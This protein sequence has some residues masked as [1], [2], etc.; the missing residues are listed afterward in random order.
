[1][2]GPVH[3]IPIAT[4]ILALAFSVVLLHRY[5]QRGG[6]HHLWWGIGALTYA[7]GTVTE[8]LTTL[9]GWHE[10]VFRAWYI[11]GALLG[12]APLAQGSVYL[13]FPRRTAD[14]LSAI[15]ITTIVVASACVLMSPIRYDLVEQYRLSGKVLEWT[16]VR[17]FSPF[18][19]TYAFVFLVGL[20]IRSA[21]HFSRKRETWHRVV[22]NVYIAVGG[23]LP[24]IGGTFTRFGH[25]EVLYVTEFVGLALIFVGYRYSVAGRLLPEQAGPAGLAVTG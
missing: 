14:A 21:W 16:W 13:H 2:R 24:G 18:I 12:G 1:M 8:S 17:R 19:N 25:V 23:L 3:Y 20:A 7:A 11:T 10:P 9:T 6:M 4:T 22:G 5:R 15:L